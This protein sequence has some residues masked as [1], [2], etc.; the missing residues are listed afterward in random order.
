MG[1]T[2]W[3]ITNGQLGGGIDGGRWDRPRAAGFM[4]LAHD[5][6]EARL[7]CQRDLPFRDFVVSMPLRPVRQPG[8]ATIPKLTGG[9]GVARGPDRVDGFALRPVWTSQSVFGGTSRGV[10]SRPRAG[11]LL[12]G[13]HVVPGGW[14]QCPFGG[15]RVV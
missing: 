11:R 7:T 14:C 5:H 2:G 3:W 4:G 9:H 13:T 12:V 8:L 6:S 10:L 1:G 15:G